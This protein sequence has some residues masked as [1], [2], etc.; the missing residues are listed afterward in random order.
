MS[1]SAAAVRALRRLGYTT[2]AAN[3]TH[4]WMLKDKTIGQIRREKEQG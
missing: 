2:T 1:L 4:Y 3:G